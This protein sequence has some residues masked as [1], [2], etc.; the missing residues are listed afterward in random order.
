M[1]VSPLWYFHF[2][3]RK[4]II[5]QYYCNKIRKLLLRERMKKKES[6][7]EGKTILSR[8]FMGALSD[9]ITFY[10]VN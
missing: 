7:D 4:L 6:D 9:E 3:R 2:S 8:M 5:S 10:V 1:E